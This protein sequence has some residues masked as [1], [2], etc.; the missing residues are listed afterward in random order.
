MSDR[1]DKLEKTA[2]RWAVGLIIAGFVLALLAG[3][4]GAAEVYPYEYT[5]TVALVALLVPIGSALLI[6]AV[7]GLYIMGGWKIA[8]FGVVF[9]G[10]FAALT[11]GLVVADVVWRD[12]GVGLL[13][14]SGA[15]FYVAGVLSA[16]VPPSVLNLWG[17]TG[18]LVGGAA[19]AVLGH[20]TD[21][22]GLL[23]FGAMAFGCA[24]GGLLGRWLARRR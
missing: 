20:V 7:G 2:T 12:I 3:V 4:L 23:L 24:V 22:W 15:G 10:G 6:G 21:F 5:E 16:R 13:A 17:N 14:L 19:L 9:V 1:L 11:Y 18:A 8:P